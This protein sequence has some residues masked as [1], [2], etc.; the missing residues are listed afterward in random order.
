MD[1]DL[2]AK[3]Y[4]ESSDQWLSVQMETSDMWCPSGVSSGTSAP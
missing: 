2:V 3:S 1:K 4:L